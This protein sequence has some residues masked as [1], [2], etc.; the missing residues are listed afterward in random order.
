MDDRKV[1]ELF[2]LPIARGYRRYRN[3]GETKERH[4]AAYY[5]FEVY[6]KYLASIA[7]AF[8]LSG[9][10]RDHRVG[11]ALK[12][13]VRPSLGEWTRFLKECL[14]FLRE[15]EKPDPE[16]L[17]IDAL[18]EGKGVRWEAPVELFN[19]LRSFRTG[20]SSSKK[21]VSLEALLQEVVAYRNR[22]LG[23]GAPLDAAHYR[24]FE[25]VFQRAFFEVLECSP[26]L[27]SMS[28][29][30][31]GSIQ[32]QDRSRIACETN[33]F[34]GLQPIRRGQPYTLPYGAPPPT[35]GALHLLGLEG[36]LVSLEPLLVAHREDVYFLNE[37][38][39]PLRGAETGVSL[40]LP[41]YLSYSTGERYRPSGLGSAEKDLFE[42]I[43]GYRVDEAR[44]SRLGE[45]LAR[46][47]EG[48]EGAE[49]TG[50][51]PGDEGG[52]RLGDY[53]IVRELGRGAMGVVFEAVQESLGRRVALKVLPGSF[54]IDPR[55]IERFHR[56]AR[57]TARIHHA[58]IVPVYDV[59]EQG[60]NHFYA[61]EF[62]DGAPLDQVLAETA[63]T[64]SGAG[65]RKSSS[66]A[67]ASYIAGAVEQ[68]A[69][70]A[71][72]LEA[73]H[74]QGLV[75]RD[76]K[77]S[78]ILVEGAA[79]GP[80]SPEGG[81]GGRYVLIDFGLVHEA[82]AEALTRSGEMVGTLYYMSPEQV[83]RGKVDARTDVYSLGVTLYEV[84]TFRAPF[85]RGS[86]HETQRAIL[87]EEP[88][89]PRRLNPRINRD[90]ETILLRAMEKNP[91]RRY[92][93]AGEL[94]ADLR[95]FLRYEPIH[96]RPLSAWGKVAR[97][98][99]R[100]K[101]GVGIAALLLVL[102][103]AAVASIFSRGGIPPSAIA[104][105]AVLPFTNVGGSPE[106]EYLAAGISEGLTSALSRLPQ[107]Y[108]ISSNSVLRFGGGQDVDPVKVGRELRVQAVVTGSVIQVGDG[109]AVSADLLDVKNGAAIWRREARDQKL[110]DLIEVEDEIARKISGKLRPDLTQAEKERLGRRLT[111]S[112]LA[113][114]QYLRGRYHW[115]RRTETEVRKA[116]EHFTRAV[117]KDPRY[118]PA[119]AGLAECHLALGAHRNAGAVPALESMPRAK[120]AAEQALM[121]DQ[122]SAEAH[123]IL[124]KVL[125][126]YDWDFEAA[127][128]GFK[129][130][131]S[132]S[133]SYVEAHHYYSHYA[134]AMGDVAA[135]ERE[136]L[137]AL[138][139]QPM[140]PTLHLHLSWHYF[141]AGEYDRARE[142]ALEGLRMA[143]NPVG[144]VI[145]AW[146]YHLTGRHEDAVR[147]LELADPAAKRTDLRAEVAYT[148]A[149]WGKRDEALKRL[150]ELE[151]LSR[152]EYVCSYELALVRLALGE[153]D[154]ALSLLVKAVDERCDYLIYLNV[155]RRVDSLREEPRFREVVR[156]VG[157]AR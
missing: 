6:L 72:G 58:N 24:R 102:A 96:A 148:Y 34:M 110:S 128:R 119:Y 57:A 40:S 36:K 93:S 63:R 112:W 101:R 62:I 92:A 114:E 73:A 123:T 15:R 8:Y 152:K 30:A 42:R 26:F 109:L 20:S 142:Q 87:F 103:G 28:L 11:A 108:V 65:G 47:P 74:R 122:G 115:N 64:R 145:L 111:A 91:Q 48:T 155:E 53:R 13:L 125:L 43:L 79:P 17:A 154:E 100:H 2:P 144:H 143:D 78:N 83:S 25:E 149:L 139:L 75:H 106:K 86:D 76:V 134:M 150:G 138:E 113:H 104:S 44:L 80:S 35:A 130:A 38:A 105:M 88:V 124:A 135:S 12:G 32:V 94:A 1:L 5:L 55:R 107:L 61:M 117:E 51:G 116:I 120:R 16:V 50:G 133:P 70:I 67:D 136:S 3:A 4:D 90:L 98:T 52:K 151:E 118:A 157:L 71:E 18:H 129:A 85:E 69:G 59:G 9:G 126:E 156:R 77:P 131:M 66:S 19:A 29:V 45:D 81:R 22:V 23:H 89:P 39:A 141:F 153:K 146:I 140:D 99:W 49:G 54:A 41:E 127:E 56:E 82:E 132:L 31:F 7:I 147:E 14:R 137:R 46:P 21:Q 27:T 10:E 97:R 33:E 68:I 60:G 95:R 121:I 37:A 84:L